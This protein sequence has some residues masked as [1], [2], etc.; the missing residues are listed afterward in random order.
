MRAYVAALALLL[1]LAA[2]SSDPA[3]EPDAAP[4]PA[5][6]TAAAPTAAEPVW[7]PCEDLAAGP[8]GRA[9]GADL[10]EETGTDDTPRCA[11]LPVEKGGPT[12]NVTYVW[13]AGGFE[14]AWAGMGQIE[15]RVTDVDIAGAANAR[16]VVNA[17]R[18]VV[19]VTGFVKT[20]DLIE[21]VNAIQLAPYDRAAVVDA[22]TEVMVTLSRHAPASEKAAASRG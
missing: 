9:L 20:G 12:L 5:T 7:N 18:G 11:F 16:L 13:Y 6:P 14:K 2:C 15:G 21:T 8:V 19:L 3:A 17:R 22:T 4:T 1:P 10:T